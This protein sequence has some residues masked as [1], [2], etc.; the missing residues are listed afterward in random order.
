MHP[1]RKTPQEEI[2]I[3]LQLNVEN[4]MNG[5]QFLNEIQQNKYDTQL[6]N[7]SFIIRTNDIETNSLFEYV[8][9][10]LETKGLQRDQN[11]YNHAIYECKY[12]TKY[13]HMIRDPHIKPTPDK[14]L[15]PSPMN[16]HRFWKS[17]LR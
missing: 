15:H 5:K 14:K 12:P 6:P 11:V 7:T 13:I 4:N 8:Y 1:V 9:T 2:N 3:T 10:L 16:V 17:R